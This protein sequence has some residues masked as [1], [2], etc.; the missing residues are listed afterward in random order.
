[1]IYFILNPNAGTNSFQKRARMIEK[2]E[3]IPNSI[4]WLTEKP[5]HASEFTKQAILDNADQVIAI[6]GDGTI[7]EVAS[8]LLYSKTPLGIIP[9]GSGNGL[10]R[11]LGIPFEFEKALS[12]ALNGQIITI[13]AGKWNERPFFCTAGIGFD[14]FVAAHFAKRGK[15]GFLNYV[16]STLQ[17]L[18]VY[19][20]I[21]TEENG[22][23]FSLTVANANQFGNNAYISPNSDLQ[24]GLLEC[25][26]IKPS[27]FL[28]FANLGISLFQKN[29]HLSPLATI[30]GIK[31]LSITAKVGLPF[32]LDGE[33]F[34][35]ENDRIQIDVLPSSLRVVK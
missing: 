35:L 25:V 32:H 26:E 33:S 16:Y 31:S 19:Q 9:I 20:P 12:K 14:A 1:M 23:I 27:N 2:L 6:G 7:N 4:I 5:N 15:R 18:R 3:S 34:L 22:N 8:A 29:I 13:D 11:H 10:A 21:F 17:S 30:S 24:D 28:Q